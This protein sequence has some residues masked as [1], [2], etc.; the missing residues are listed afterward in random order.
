[1]L[2]TQNHF[3]NNFV[4]VTNWGRRYLG[5][6]Y[7][8]YYMSSSLMIPIKKRLMSFVEQVSVKSK[9]SSD[10]FLTVGGV[11]LINENIQVDTFLSQTLKD[12]PSM[13]SAGIGV[14]YR[15]DRYNDCLLYTNDP[16]DE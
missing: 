15:I 1:M 14:S 10:I 16:A 7:E 8:Q 2:I 12:T 5:S 6:A 9:L 13:F 11:F 4:L 3:L